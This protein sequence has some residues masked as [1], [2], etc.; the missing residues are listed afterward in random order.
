MAGQ[1]PVANTP[2]VRR[3]NDLPNAQQAGMLSNDKQFQSFAGAR[4]I[5]SGIQLSPTA[6]GEF[7]RVFCRV[8]SRR[9][10]NT[11][12][13]AAHKFQTLRTEFDAWS[14]RIPAQR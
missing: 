14:G 5:K 7:I 9:D 2:R 11:N 1:K 3:F 4:A 8:T 10:L 6:A 12:Q 13:A